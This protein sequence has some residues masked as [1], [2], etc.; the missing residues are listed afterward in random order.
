VLSEL[1]ATPE[2]LHGLMN[3]TISLL[4]RCSQCSQYSQ[5]SQV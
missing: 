4:P 3:K 5:H 1:G 2:L